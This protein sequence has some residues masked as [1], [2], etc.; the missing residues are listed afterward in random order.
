MNTTQKNQSFTG[1][2]SPRNRVWYARVKSFIRSSVESL[3]DLAMP[4][5]VALV[6]SGI[7]A[8]L[9]GVLYAIQPGFNGDYVELVLTVIVMAFEWA[10]YGGTV[11]F[12]LRILGLMRF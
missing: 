12:V 5:L 9:F 6:L 7:V 4:W 1:D 10:F 11:L 2:A 3:I 8:V